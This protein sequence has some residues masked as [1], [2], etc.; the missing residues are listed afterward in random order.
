MTDEVKSSR[1]TFGRVQFTVVLVVSLRKRLHDT[2][3][4]L[5]LTRQANVH[6][7]PTHGH[8]ER[9]IGELEPMY[10]RAQRPRMK[11]VPA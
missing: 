3:D 10:I 2:V 1:R 4:L 5:R 11:V 8:I 7:Q 6:E 9:V